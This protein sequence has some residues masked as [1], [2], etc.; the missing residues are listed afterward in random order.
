M[1]KLLLTMLLGTMVIV[2]SN[3]QIIITGAMQNPAGDDYIATNPVPG[4]APFGNGY[5]YVQFMATEDITNATNFSIILTRNSASSATGWVNASNTN[6]YKVNIPSLT[7]AKGTFFYLIGMD[8]KFNGAASVVFTG[9][10]NIIQFD[11]SV[12]GADGQGNAA[13]SATAFFPDANPSGIAVFN[14]QSPTATTRP[15]D[16]IFFGAASRPPYLANQSPYYT[17]PTYDS[18]DDALYFDEDNTDGNSLYLTATGVEGRFYKFVGVYNTDTQK[19]TTTR[20]IGT[21]TNPT[22]LSNLESSSTAL[23]NNVLPIQLSAF[24]AKSSNQGI[25]LSWSTASEKDNN[26]FQ[27]W[28][29]AGNNVAFEAVG[30]KIQGAGNSSTTQKYSFLD[31]K[32]GTGANYY[33]LQQVD[34]NGA[35]FYSKEVVAYA[36]LANAGAAINYADGKLNLAF[37]AKNNGSASVVVFDINGRKVSA[38]SIATIAGVNEVATALSLAKGVY[39]VKLALDGSTAT[40]K[41]V[42]Y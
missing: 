14:T 10:A 9:T 25:Q 13:T 29:K 22:S 6:S 19:W 42:V 32:P 23:T 31:S 7:A 12:A 5:E 30:D 3:A 28:R 38:S 39:V 40:Q 16:A 11:Q 27:V 18:G 8:P 33:K 26:Y 21:N 4:S 15:I 17:V 24:S 41:I 2:Q 1:K 35:D 20:V 36:G 37:E 34:N